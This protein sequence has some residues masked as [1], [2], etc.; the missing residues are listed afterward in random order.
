MHQHE[1]PIFCTKVRIAPTTKVMQVETAAVPRC[2][3][4][5]VD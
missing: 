4:L 1:H 2:A 5:E 3:S